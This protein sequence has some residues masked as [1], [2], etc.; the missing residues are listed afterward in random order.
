MF[1]AITVT[2]AIIVLIIMVL[3]SIIRKLLKVIWEIIKG[4]YPLTTV[5]VAG[6]SLCMLYLLDPRLIYV[7]MGSGIMFSIAV[8][9][10]LYVKFS[11]MKRKRNSK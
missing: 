7:S 4:E 6:I 3:S 5:L 10:T 2:I 9:S 1:N 11:Q 8:I